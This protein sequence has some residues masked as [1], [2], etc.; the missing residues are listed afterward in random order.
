MTEILF[1]ILTVAL[2]GFF[3]GSEIAFVQAN[4]LKL[5]IATRRGTYA[6]RSLEHFLEK[7]DKFLATTLAGHHVVNVIYATLIALF[8]TAPLQA[9]W[10]TLTGAA[11]SMATLLLVQTVLASLVIMIF[12]EILPKALY[13]MKADFVIGAVAVP[14][15][16]MNLLLRPIIHLA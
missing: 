4:K 16:W 6:S 9:F 1:I 10:L 13:R 8:F 14:M 7:P 2:S 11:P 3:S 12:G 5:E 15:K